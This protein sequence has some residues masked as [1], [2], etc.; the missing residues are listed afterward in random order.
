MAKRKTRFVCQSCGRVTAAYVGRC[1]K[2][3]EFNSMVEEVLQEDAPAAA[4]S[5]LR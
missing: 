4:K 3:S 1:P 5:T 2:C